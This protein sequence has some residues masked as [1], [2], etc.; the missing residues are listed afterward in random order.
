[1]LI[2]LSIIYYIIQFESFC[3][4]PWVTA[5][6]SKS[7]HKVI[8]TARYTYINKST[9]K[10][11]SACMGYLS[12]IRNRRM[13]F[14]ISTK[15]TASIWQLVWT[16]EQTSLSDLHGKLGIKESNWKNVGCEYLERQE[17]YSPHNS[18]WWGQRYGL[19]ALN[20]FPNRGCIQKKSYLK[21]INK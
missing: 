8:N 11:I 9:N 14:K 2:H 19:V 1:M 3:C 17:W 13:F 15:T 4:P 16:V 7:L 20:E 21:R 12:M 18:V 10:Y 5:Y 6:I